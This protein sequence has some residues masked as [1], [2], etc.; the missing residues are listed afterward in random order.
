MGDQLQNLLD[1]LNSKGEKTGE[2]MTA[3]E[4]HQKGLWHATAHVWIYTLNN[5]VLLQKRSEEATTYPKLWDISAAGHVDTGETPE[6][7][8]IREVE[9]EI[10]IKINKEKL[11]KIFIEKIDVIIPIKNW[12]NREFQYVYLLCLEDFSKLKLQEEEVSK[13]ELMSLK[14]F[15]DV[16]N[17][18]VIYK[19]FVP[20]G[21]YYQKVIEAIK[22]NLNKL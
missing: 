14:K 8:A 9:E 13:V 1:V 17:D 7:A 4:V 3:L 6:E 19:K 12:P 22:T 21:K 5:Q 11:K 2:V 18:P 15:E 20:H 10:G 16:I